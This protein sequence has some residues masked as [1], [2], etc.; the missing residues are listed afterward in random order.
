MGHSTAFSKGAR[1]FLPSGFQISNWTLC[2]SSF[3]K[4]CNGIDISRP[5]S[6]SLIS[7][8]DGGSRLH[9]TQHQVVNGVESCGTGANLVAIGIK[10]NEGES[11]GGD[12][13]H[14]LGTVKL[15]IVELGLVEASRGE[16]G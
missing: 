9:C 16:D 8:S 10:D 5:P 12:T 6:T 11:G 14:A 1:L 13:V 7:T 15:P 4:A 3:T 2:S